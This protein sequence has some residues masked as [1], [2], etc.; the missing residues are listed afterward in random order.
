MAVLNPTAIALADGQLG[1]S[2]A[3]LYTASAVAGTKV[4]IPRGGLVLV[5]TDSVKRT[6]NV[7][8]NRT[9][10][11]RRVAPKAYELQAGNDGTYVSG[12]VIVLEA[13]DLLEGDADAAAVVD[14]VISGYQENP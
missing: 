12:S 8:V 14:Y 6:V 5:N 1:N 13:S 4:V 7:Y 3:T 10:T 9:G 11:S 2:K